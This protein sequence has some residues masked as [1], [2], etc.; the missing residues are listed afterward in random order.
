MNIGSLCVINVQKRTIR[1]FTKKAADIF[2]VSI[3]SVKILGHYN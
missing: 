3:L 1:Q 2:T